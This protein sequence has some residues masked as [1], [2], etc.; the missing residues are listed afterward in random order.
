MHSGR[1]WAMLRHL[2]D[3]TKAKSHQRETLAKILN[4]ALRELGEEVRN[5]INK[6]LPASPEESHPDYRGAA[7]EQLERDIEVGEVQAA[8]HELNCRSAAGPEKIAN[9]ALKN[10]NEAAIASLTALFN[11]CWRERRLPKT[12]RTAK[13][14]PILKPGKTTSIQ[15]LRPISQTSCVMK[16]V[17]NVLMNHWQKYLEENDLFSESMIGFRSKFSTS[18]AMIHLKVEIIDGKTKTR[19]NK[20]ILGLDL[21]S[22]FDKVMNAAVLAQMS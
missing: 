1:T 10:L 11:K 15:H 14:I 22:A 19:D 4:K 17:V 7:N 16:V 6:Y 3:E 2:L 21:L 9:K 12:W 20:A 8:L 18:G 5:R 13:S